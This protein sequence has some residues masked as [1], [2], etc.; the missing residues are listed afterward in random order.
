LPAC[1]FAS[2][3]FLK[4]FPQYQPT[5]SP[6]FVATT[7]AEEKLQDQ[8]LI[9]EGKQDRPR[10]L[11]ST[12]TPATPKGNEEKGR[13]DEHGDRVYE[14]ISYTGEKFE[15]PPSLSTVDAFYP[16]N[17]TIARYTTNSRF[18]YL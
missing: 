13:L 15:I 16:Q 14:G 10:S 17:I 2:R 6:G 7:E 4:H 11:S 12:T 8:P 9:V 3:V 18:L 5:V 1:S